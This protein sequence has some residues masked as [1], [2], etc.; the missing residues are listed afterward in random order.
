MKVTVTPDPT[1]NDLVRE[2]SQ[3]ADKLGAEM[4]RSSCADS[5]GLHWKKIVLTYDIEHKNINKK[6]LPRIFPY[7]GNMNFSGRECL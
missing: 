2:I 4:E 3:I 7:D 1:E 5:S 6:M